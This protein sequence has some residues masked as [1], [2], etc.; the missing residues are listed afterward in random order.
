MADTWPKFETKDLGDSPEDDAERDRRWQAYDRE[1]KALIARGG[2]HKDEDGWWVDDATG[3]LIGPDP[4]IERPLTDA[5]LATMRPIEETQPDLAVKLRG[6]PRSETPKKS[7]SIRLDADLLD[8]LRK[9][10]K[11][12]QSRVNAALR[13]WAGL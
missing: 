1:M 9:S 8:H 4:E 5:D 12:W 10:G 6:R 2:V 11:G 13:E 3:A 7:T